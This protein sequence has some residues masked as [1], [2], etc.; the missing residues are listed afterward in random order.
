MAI[1]R[2]PAH[3][4]HATAEGW[5]TLAGELTATAPMVR[6]FAFQPSAAAVALIHAGVDAASGVLAARTVNTAVDTS[7]AA[8][9]YTANEQTSAA[10]VNAISGAL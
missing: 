7:G 1:L 8:T 9:A 2:A 10:M 5:H 6:G 4:L 3:E